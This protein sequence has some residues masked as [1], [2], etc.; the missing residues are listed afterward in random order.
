MLMC[1]SGNIYQAKPEKLCTINNSPRKRV[2]T[3]PIAYK[4][5]NSANYLSQR[6]TT[7]LDGSWTTEETCLMMCVIS[8]IGAATVS[9]TAEHTTV[10]YNNVVNSASC[11]KANFL[12]RQK[13]RH[14]IQ[15]KLKHLEDKQNLAVKLAD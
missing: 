15:G 12:I 1:E 11:K 13:T 8:L 10:L 3:T 2:R 5:A 7:L 6:G 14:Q 4:R 9:P